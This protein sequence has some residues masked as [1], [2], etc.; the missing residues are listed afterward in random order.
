MAA[1]ARGDY[2]EALKYYVAGADQYK[3]NA[4][5]A[6]R[7]YEFGDKKGE[8]PPNYHEAMRFY[9]KA[10]AQGSE[11]A[12]YRIGL[13]Y[14]NGKGV[15]KDMGQADMWMRKAVARNDAAAGE[16]LRQRQAAERVAEATKLRQEEAASAARARAEWDALPQE[17]KQRRLAAQRAAAAA[18]SR[19]DDDGPG[20]AGWMIGAHLGLGQQPFSG[21]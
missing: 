21:D 18:P 8:Y 7:Y 5:N 6:G 9:L 20:F 13:L 4:F 10:A 12:M 1:D 19:S 16:W 2:S 15:P 17:E 3:M 14:A 11:A